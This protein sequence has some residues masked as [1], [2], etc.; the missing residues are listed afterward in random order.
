MLNASTCA[1]VLTLVLGAGACAEGE[2]V[3]YDAGAT[4]GNGGGDPSGSGG[5]SG[6]G[7]GNGSNGSSTSNGSS[8][9]TGSNGT[10]GAGAGG[11]GGSGGSGCGDMCDGDEDGVLDGADECADTPALEPVNTVGCG[12]S[13]L[14]PTL[15]ETWPPYGLTWAPTGD[16]GRA[17]GLT[18][19]YT[20][21]DHGDLFHIVWVP[22]DDP[23]TPCGVSLDGPIEVAEQWAF[24]AAG[25]NLPGGVM[26]F[27][28]TTQIP[29][30]D[31]TSPTLTGRLTLSIVGESGEPL[32]FEGVG[33]LGV[34]A[35]DGDYGTEIPGSGFAVAVL[36][37]VQDASLV[38]TPYL[39]YFDAAPTPDPGPGT[40]VSFG[41]SFYDE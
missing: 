6:T 8:G 23:A 28:N 7:G 1:L 4:S 29:L 19:T 30:A 2:T 36:I 39:D 24:S 18:W 11:A 33:A 26:V 40:A 21:I 38:W 34:T 27:T 32:P 31:G 25:S 16:A 22:C 35:R 14:D 15:Q 37:E 3:A 5:A 13:Q 9:S 20:G 12:D 17:G 10:G 41:G